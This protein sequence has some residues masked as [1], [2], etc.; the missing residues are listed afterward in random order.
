MHP[1]SSGFRAVLRQPAVIAGE[2]AWRWA[3]GAASWA[4]LLL[5]LR[6]IFAGVDV[7]E[8]EY[9]VARRSDA[10]LIADAW[11]RVLVQVLPQLAHAALILIPALTLFW[12]IAATMG[13]AATLRA[14]CERNSGPTLENRER[15]GWATHRV[16]GPLFALNVLRAVFMLATV[17]DMIG[18]PILPPYY[19][20]R[21]LPYVTPKIEAWKRRVLREKE[22]SDEHDYHLHGL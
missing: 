14:L 9:L 13:R 1:V 15:Q 3:F 11:A 2:I 5:T 16:W 18:V 4:L 19:S 12:V 17:G 10:F 22:F 20:L 7:S 8:A 6:D 21:L